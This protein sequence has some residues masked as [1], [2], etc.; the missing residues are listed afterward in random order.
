MAHFAGLRDPRRHV[1]WVVRALKVLQVAR[2]AGGCG[3]IVVAVDVALP[4]RHTHV[5]PSQRKR[6][7][8]VIKGR[9]HPR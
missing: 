4:A 7:L 2:H 8:R 5:R 9:R 3:Q 6:G 1:V